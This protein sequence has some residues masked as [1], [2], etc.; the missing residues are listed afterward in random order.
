MK[1]I[2]ENVIKA[3]ESNLKKME[4]NNKRI[5]EL[6]VCRDYYMSQEDLHS[7]YM[8]TILNGQILE[9]IHANMQL[10]AEYDTF[11]KILILA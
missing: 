10:Y 5:D 2:F 8:A 1:A 3:L 4:E 6:E 9:L 7:L 11:K